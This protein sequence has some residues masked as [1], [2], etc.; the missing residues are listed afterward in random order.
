MK[1]SSSLISLAIGG[2]FLY[3]LLRLFKTSRTSGNTSTASALRKAE[4]RLI[5]KVLTE[6]GYSEREAYYWS[7]VSKM[8]TAAFT[9]NLYKTYHNLF[10]M[11]NP[12]KRDTTSIG[13]SP[14]GFAVYKTP[15]ESVK[16]LILYMQEWRYPKDFASLEDQLLFMKQKGYYEESFEKYFSLVKAWEAK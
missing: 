3:F 10:G 8:E 11:K 4:E 16:D 5:I 9:S 14:S 15:L 12:V 6:A 1:N 13:E 2:I 7:L